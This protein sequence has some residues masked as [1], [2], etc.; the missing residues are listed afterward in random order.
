MTTAELQ[1]PSV[2]GTVG[3]RVA[4]R[5]RTEDSVTRYWIRPVE[6]ASRIVTGVYECDSMP[7]TLNQAAAHAADAGFIWLLNPVG[8]GVLVG[9]VR[10]H[11]KA[12]KIQGNIRVTSPR[13]TLEKMTFT[14][15]PSGTSLVVG[16]RRGTDASPSASVRTANTGMTI[17]PGSAALT[18][19][20]TVQLSTTNNRSQEWYATSVRFE[21]VEGPVLDAG[22]GLVLRQADAGDASDNR[23][24]SLGFEWAEF[25][26]M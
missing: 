23:Q 5:S 15:T 26:D 8:S 1:Y 12:D 21:E 11:F 22:E 10:L 14:G 20:P 24:I 19:M 13:F 18:F 25:T 3:R 4:A 7:M 9:L 2:T 16:K 6:E 17:T